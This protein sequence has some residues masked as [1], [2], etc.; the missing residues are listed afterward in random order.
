MGWIIVGAVF[1]LLSA[2]LAVPAAVDTT[3]VMKGMIP[4]A[5]VI[6]ICGIALILI[7]AKR[8]K[9]KVQKKAVQDSLGANDSAI[10]THISGLPLADGAECNVILG[11]GE[12]VFE[13][14]GTQIHL[15]FSKIRD[16]ACKTETEIRNNYVS[17]IGGAVGGA[18]LFGP[19]GAMIG[20]RAKKKT[21]IKTTKYFM[22]AYNKDD[23]T[24]YIA[25]DCKNFGWKG[26]KFAKAFQNQKSITP[27]QI[28]L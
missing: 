28:S 13:R 22:I 27:Q 6:L 25:F 18:F 14:T 16:V 9:K 7:G 23:E 17:S 8:R 10:F 3:G 12:Y 26:E 4:F 5:V 20:G 1:A 15:S 21:D 24:A 2:F 11:N 19:V